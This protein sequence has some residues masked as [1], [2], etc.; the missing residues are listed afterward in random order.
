MCI[1]DRGVFGV[2]GGRG[3]ETSHYGSA[4]SRYGYLGGYAHT[5]VAADDP[6]R[7]AVMEMWDLEEGIVAKWATDS[8]V[9]LSVKP[10]PYRLPYRHMTMYELPDE[11]F[12][13]GELEP[14]IGLQEELNEMLTIDLAHRRQQIA[15]YAMWQDV[16]NEP[17]VVNAMKSAQVGGIV[18]I[19]RP[20]G[21]NE[22]PQTLDNQVSFLEQPRTSG[23]VERSEFRSIENMYSVSGVNELHDAGRSLKTHQTATAVAAR[24]DA[25]NMRT[26]EK[27]TIFESAVV[28]LIRMSLQQ[29]QL[30]LSL[31]HI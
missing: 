11:F 21:A 10:M 5:G 20:V 30:M 2:V 27:N 19:P 12:G 28:D 3:D 7:V 24:E 15:K 13:I 8:S 6:R 17:E 16:A 1:R 22:G 25:M 9:F 29:A 31:I 14:L 18:P 23:Q 26:S 4:A